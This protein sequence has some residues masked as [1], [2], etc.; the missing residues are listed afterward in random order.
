LERESDAGKFAISINN[1]VAGVAGAA[2]VEVVGFVRAVI[3]LPS[4]PN[5]L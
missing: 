1:G 3:I 4:L 2:T 5:Y